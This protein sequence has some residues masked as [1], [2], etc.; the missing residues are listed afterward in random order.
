LRVAV[1]GCAASL[2]G[3]KPCPMKP[4]V[5]LILLSVT[6][7][8]LLAGWWVKNR[9]R[10]ANDETAVA[11]STPTAEGRFGPSG[12]KRLAPRHG[13]PSSP[14]PEVSGMPT[15]WKDL[16]A[17]DLKEFIRRLR[18]AGCPEETVQDL[19]LAEVN[20]RY[21]AMNRQLWPERDSIK[22][23]WEVQKN[24]PAGSKKNRER[25]RRAAE[26]RKE[27]SALLVEL[28]G[29]DVEKERRKSESFVDNLDYNERRVSFLPEAKREAA[30]KILDELDDKMQEFQTR[31]RGMYDAQY[32]AERK[33]LEEQRSVA[34]AQVLTPDEVRE[35]E[36]RNSQVATQLSYDLRGLTVSREQYDAIYDVRKRYGDSIYNY[37]EIETKA[38]RDQVA[39]N[40]EALQA[41]LVAA[42]GP[43]K[44]REYQRSQDYSYQEL[45]RLATRNDLPVETAAKVYD[46][47]EA[48][49]ESV[50]QIKA[51]PSLTE[52][53]RK[54][55]LDTIREETR[56]AVTNSLGASF[57]SYLRQGGSW[58]NNLAPARPRLAQ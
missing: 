18:G 9:N 2:H 14:E 22:P 19:V 48:A 35:F 49:E 15:S 55:A 30:T 34:L 44:A 43:D 38:E 45:I 12:S 20:R 8:V 5:W 58:I 52:E 6:T 29:V 36:R 32:R 54:T 7:N 25:S 24:D 37:V 27:K 41:D 33:Q 28:L 57:P 50:K 46:F 53:Q 11:A 4:F 21:A 40:K 31:N 3:N 17:H 1:I 13:E 16:Q 39:K 47:K 42:L 51:D 10:D 23:F 26:L 56:Q